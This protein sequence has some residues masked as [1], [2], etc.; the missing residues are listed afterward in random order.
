MKWFKPNKSI[1]NWEEDTI[2]FSSKKTYRVVSEIDDNI[3][4]CLMPNNLKSTTCCAFKK[5][6][7]GIKYKILEF[8]MGY[9]HNN[10]NKNNRYNTT[11]YM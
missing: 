4:V 11:K 6:D 1:K 10:I 8:Q 3:Y 9:K 7:E 5:Q 2:I